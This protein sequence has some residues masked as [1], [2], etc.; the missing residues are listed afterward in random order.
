MY[1]A[2]W[3]ETD[4]AVKVIT[5]MQN[6]SPLQGVHPQD[7]S[8]MLPCHEPAELKQMS[9]AASQAEKLGKQHMGS[10]SQGQQCCCK[11]DCIRLG[12]CSRVYTGVLKPE[13]VM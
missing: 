8:T 5:Q 2:K 13:P 3:Q 12:I 4:V 6:L 7:P 9:D 10:D 11:G 1:L